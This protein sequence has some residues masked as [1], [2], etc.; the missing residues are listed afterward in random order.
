[1]NRLNVTLLVGFF[2]TGYSHAA[3]QTESSPA[4]EHPMA[5]GHHEGVNQRGDQVMGFS[6][7][8]TTHHFRL[9]P[10]GGAIEVEANDPHDTA[11]RDQIR[12]HLQHIGGMFAA[13]D[14]NAPM[15][16]HDQAPPGVSTLK[17]L[18][19]SVRYE[20]QETDSGGCVRIT[21]HN[22]QAIQAVHD[23]LRFQ[24]TDHQTGDPLQVSMPVDG[25]RK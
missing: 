2:L 1:M 13:G 15:L 22:T 4:Q 9:Y 20:F 23:F 7:Q 24:I 11:G 21:T 17:R 12:M 6:H 19:S 16:I 8:K 3:A 18:K 25:T 5:P 10:D 14:F